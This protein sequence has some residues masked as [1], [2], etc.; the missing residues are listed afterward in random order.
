MVLALPKLRRVIEVSSLTL[1]LLTC[2]LSLRAQVTTGTVRGEV[3]DQSGAVVPNATVTITDPNTK[4]SQTAQSGG[5]GEFQFNNLLVGTYTITVQTPS[6]ANFSALTMNDVRVQL[7]QVTDVTAVLQ[8]AEASASVTVSA[9]GVELVDTTS[10]NLARD[11]SSRQVIDLAQTGTGAGIYNL[12]L[13]SPNVASSGGVGLGTGGSVGGQRPRNN[14]FIV[15]GI[16][17]NDKAVSGPQIYVSPESVGEFNLLTNQTSAEFA[18]STG[19]QFITVTKSGSNDF[20]GTVFEFMQNRHLNAIDNLQTLAG[21]TRDTNPRFDQN[22][23]GFNIGGPLYIPRFGEGGKPT[24]HWSGRNKLFFFF[25]FEQIGL[26][27]AASPGNVSAPTAEGIALLQGLSGLSSNN[28]SIF[29]QFVPVAATNNAG[30]IPVCTVLRDSGA[31]CPVGNELAIPIGNIAFAA[32]NFQ[33]NRNIVFNL[34]FTQSPNT[35]HHSRFIFNRQR[36]I[37]N[38]AT[39][40]E[41]FALVPTDG[42][43]FSYTLIHN[44]SPKLTNETR[45][46]YRRYLQTFP[47]SDTTF[48]GLDQFPNIGLADLGLNIGPD[49]NAPQFTI[50]NSYQVVDQATYTHHQHS[51]KFGVDWRNIISPQSFVQRSRGDYQYPNLD[52]F[53]RD[54]QPS[55][56]ER[57]VGASP[58]YGNQHLFYAFGQDDW[59]IRPR[60]TLNLGVNYV[61]Q[62][63]PLTA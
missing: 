43:L 49:Q 24:Y 22:R 25:Q 51:I 47:V 15:D 14:N 54:I 1:I 45:L 61:Y 29:R 16:D 57:T 34:D 50:E 32:P 17:N 23:Y 10:I 3:K 56:G 35:E 41:F 60:L 48:P 59:R 36:T 44:F 9:G 30:T 53:L 40:P 18:R 27:Q 38:A 28:F 55:F 20:H 4:N 21:I 5:G 11:F 58:Y 13:I 31:N 39:F 26:G 19:G 37:D 8:P 7:N 46:A 2:G 63:V 12:A 6:G 33:N 62:Q 42:R 52:L